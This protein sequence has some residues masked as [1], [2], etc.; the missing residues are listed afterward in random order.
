MLWFADVGIHD[1]PEVEVDL[2]ERCA[3][4]LDVDAQQCAMGGT[5]VLHAITEL[6]FDWR[7]YKADGALGSNAGSPTD[8]LITRRI[9]PEALD[10]VSSFF[11]N[12]LILVSSRWMR[13]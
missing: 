7:P 2:I 6:S 1:A 12:T 4:S 11:Q 10:H 8:V 3:R 5:S 9:S 13:R